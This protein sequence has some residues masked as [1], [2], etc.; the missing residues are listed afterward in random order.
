M[1]TE[2]PRGPS[3]RAEALALGALALLLLAALLPALLAGKALAPADGLG[4]YLPYRLAAAAA[5]WQGELPS[6]N[7]YMW[8]GMPLLG[9][10]QAGVL[11]PGNWPF[12]LLPPA[13]AMDLTVA[14]AYA[15]A[16]AGAYGLARSL[17]LRPA[18]AAFAALPFGLGGWLWGHLEHLALVQAAACWPWLLWALHRHALTGS[19]A[20]ARGAV[21]AFAMMVLAGH[22]QTAILGAAYALAFALWLG[23]APGWSW[24][25]WA[26]RGGALAGLGGA[27]VAPQLLPALAAIAQ[28]Q[29]VALPYAALAEHA[30]PL[31]SFLAAWAPLAFG[32]PGDPL[33][34]GPLPYWGP[35]PFGGELSAHVGLV[36]LAMAALALLRWRLLGPLRFWALAG[37]VA[38]LVALGPLTPL[39]PLLAKLPAFGGLRVPARHLMVSALAVGLLGGWAWQALAEGAWGGRA[40]AVAVAVALGPL[41][42]L[43]GGL[44]AWGGALVARWAPFAP[45]TVALNQ[46][47]APTAWPFLGPLA[48]AGCFALA[49]GLAGRWRRAAAGGVL[50]LLAIDLVAFAWLEGWAFVAPPA[51]LLPTRLPQ[52][53]VAGRWLG[54]SDAPYP[55]LDP[56]LAVA[57]PAPGLGLFQDRAEALGY[58]PLVPA[59]HARLLGFANHAGALGQPERLF[60]PQAPLLALLGVEELRLG[61]AQA[62]RWRARLAQAQWVELGAGGCAC[63]VGEGWVEG[64]ACGC[65]AGRGGACACAPSPVAPGVV[66]YRRAAY[67][68]AWWVPKAAMVAPEV[69]DAY[70]QGRGSGPWE[71]AAWVLLDATPQD[72]ASMTWPSTPDASGPDAPQAVEAPE[73]RKMGR[74]AYEAKGG[75]AGWLVVSEAF[76][77]GWQVEL[78]GQPVAL[79]RA[80][81]MQMALPVPAGPW[82]VRLRH[83][84]TG[85]PWP[86]GLVLLAL[87]ALLWP[88]RPRPWGPGPAAPAGGA[89]PPLSTP[90]A[91]A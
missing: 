91:P 69:A 54:L 43:V 17:G 26:L 22:P 5:W 68:P 48:L 29:R 35:G 86:Y 83:E 74:L 34:Q 10:L 31:K 89:Q 14:Q 61:Q 65:C 32:S 11:F 16:L 73:A 85:G 62:K 84:P 78:N 38:W 15:C 76:D 30:L 33:G 20:A 46:A 58:D 90:G 41:L 19:Q 77:P 87:G 12:L 59:R 45:P 50:G 81:A 18:A 8:G 24:G 13:W 72:L 82:R 79:W 70:V 56:A 28:S 7:P 52:P 80:N 60:A 67:P 4:A 63:C 1:T 51:A 53:P 75:A 57:L 40:R 36:A 2:A 64:K 37:G 3:W 71:P 42:L 23:P 44:A 55:Y 21:L 47:L 25:A 88:R 49:L 39:H 6:W 9:A 66:A 27:L